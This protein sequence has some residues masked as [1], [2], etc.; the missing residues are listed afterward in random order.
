[1]K[2]TTTQGFGYLA[3]RLR[4]PSTYAG[5]A[6]LAPVLMGVHSLGDLSKPEIAQALA[7]AAAILL[8][9]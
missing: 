1:M 5:L 6:L 4:E 3:R 9:G 2:K 7:A 8:P